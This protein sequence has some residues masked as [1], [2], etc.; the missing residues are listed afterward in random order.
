MAIQEY[1]TVRRLDTSF[2]MA[3]TCLSK[4]RHSSNGSSNTDRQHNQPRRRLDNEE[5]QTS[6]ATGKKERE[7]ANPMMKHKIII[8]FGPQLKSMLRSLICCAWRGQYHPGQ[9]AMTSWA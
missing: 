1:P 8:L 3:I 7:V 2:G 5:L 9:L 6:K 4:I